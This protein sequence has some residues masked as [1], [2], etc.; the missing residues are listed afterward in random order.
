M[1]QTDCEPCLIS[2]RTVLKGAG[3]ATTVAIA[4]PALGTGVAFAST[5]ADRRGDV[6]V[7]VFLRGGMDGLSVVAPRTQNAGADHYLQARPTIAVD[8]GALL[9]LDADLGLHPAM[10]ALMPMWGN[11]DLA[12][13]PTAGFPLDNRSH[14]TVQRQMD[15]GV[16]TTAAR[17]NGWLARYL[18]NLQATTPV[19]I[20]AA[21]IPRGE[22]SLAGSN[23]S[24]TMGSV[25]RFN[26]AGFNLSAA[27]AQEALRT[28]HSGASN[29][30]T[31]R[32][33]QALDALDLVAN[34]DIT[35]P[36]NGAVYPT[37]GQ[38]RGFGEQMRQIAQLIRADVG[39]EA[40]ATRGNL[41]W[42]THGN[43]GT[44]TAG[45]NRNSLE[46]LAQVLAAFYTDLGA[47]RNRVTVVLMT[48]FGRTFRENGSFGTDHGRAST[49]MVIGGGIRG[50]LYGDWPGLAPADIDRNG[51]RVTTDY[52]NV[53]LDI[54][55]HRLEAPAVDRILPGFVPD[56]AQR[57]N[58]ADPLPP[59]DTVPEPAPPVEEPVPEPTTPIVVPPSAP[60]VATYLWTSPDGGQVTID[61]P[62]PADDPVITELEA[63]RALVGGAAA[64]YV[65]VV[66]DNSVGTADL[67]APIVVV[68]DGATALTHREAW[69]A[70]ELWQA[71]DSDATFVERTTALVDRIQ[72][73]A[74]AAPGSV[75]TVIL[76][77]SGAAV[78]PVEVRL[79]AP[80]GAELVL[81]PAEVDLVEP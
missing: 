63:V 11:G 32:A 27:A 76:A 40:A 19:G 43:Q 17:N 48:E 52:R 26:I 45:N 5:N 70:V 71:G 31:D 80:G 3:A 15:Y 22:P 9:P 35:P 57:L 58:L 6:V 36:A 2:R 74:T 29:L 41:N 51:L 10:S 1:T 18:D 39:I 65:Q 61:V 55:E 62:A 14:F 66:L 21:D 81:V 49:M 72:G 68:D 4:V 73:S 37:T 7:N 47:L 23:V 75:T 54:L 12:L 79:V 42:D 28:L 69:V 56:P 20:R 44:W 24:I 38:G 60:A 16:G 33:T 59:L 13:I 67:V 50:G 77:A 78:A 34:A 53:L 8:P 30:V 25:E 64:S 46:A